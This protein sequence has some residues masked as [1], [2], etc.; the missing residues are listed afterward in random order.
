MRWH[1]WQG[2][3]LAIHRSQTPVLAGH[4]CVVALGNLL[5]LCASVTKQY[6]FVLA[7]GGIY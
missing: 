7:N 3:G 4:H 5:N 1:Y 2:I 6:N